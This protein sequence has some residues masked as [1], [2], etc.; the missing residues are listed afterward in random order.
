MANTVP[1][2]RAATTAEVTSDILPLQ[3]GELALVTTGTGSTLWVLDLASAIAVGPTV[4]ATQS[5][6]GRWLLIGEFGSSTVHSGVAVVDFGAFPGGGDAQVAVAG[7][8]TI[9]TSSSVSAW[10]AP[11]AA[12][13]EH[14]VDE[15]VVDGPDVFACDVVAGV[16]FTIKA[17]MARNTGGRA[18]GTWIVAWEWS[19]HGYRTDRRNVRC[20]GGR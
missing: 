3:S 16:G 18:Y 7:Q 8:T 19:L 2:Y 11:T 20:E 14:S 10:L 1:V 12:T 13:A 6:A 9:S 5:G 4:L 17:T 15:A